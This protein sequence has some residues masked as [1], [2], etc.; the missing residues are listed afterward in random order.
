MLLRDLEYN[1]VEN[2]SH[3]TIERVPTNC[4]SVIIVSPNLISY[5]I[6]T[7]LTN[8]ITPNFKHMRLIKAFYFCPN[9]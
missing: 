9:F 5:D 4:E 6:L 3:L 7:V 8:D 2:G 1:W